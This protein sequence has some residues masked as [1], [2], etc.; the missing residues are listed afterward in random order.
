MQVSPLMAHTA[1]ASFSNFIAASYTQVYTGNYSTVVGD[2]TLNFGTGG[3]SAS[4]FTWD[5]TSN[6]VIQF[7]FD[8]SATS[9]D[10]AEDQ[11]EA[12]VSA[13]G[14]GNFATCL[15]NYSSG[16][17]A[18]CSL[19]ASN[20]TSVRV[21]ARFSVAQAGNPVATTAVS[22]LSQYLGP[23]ADVYFYDNSG[24]T[25]ARIQN[26]TSFDYGCT[27]ISIDRT[28]S[29]SSQF[30]NNN[31]SNYLSSKSFR[32]I[33]TNNTTSG[34]Y[35]I[36]LYYTQAEINGWQTATGQSIASARVVKVSNGNYI[37]DV[38]P[39]T[40]HLADVSTVAA[41]NG[42]F[43]TD[44]IISGDFSSTGFSGFG[45][46]LPGSATTLPVRWL[47]FEGAK[48][49]ETALLT[50]KTADEYNNDHFEIET[51]KNGADFYRIGIVKGNNNSSTEQ[52]YQFTDSF[53]ATG[54]NHYRLVQ[55]DIDGRKSY[56]KTISLS[57]DQLVNMVQLYPNPG[58]ENLFINFTQPLNTAVLQILSLDGKLIKQMQRGYMYRNELLHIGDLPGG[59]YL[60]KINTGTN[61]YK[62][63][64]V[65][66]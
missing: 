64:F 49:K 12:T 15:S 40:P 44:Y 14:A 60:L 50:W 5:G 7:C 6:I 59:T 33:P 10:P 42:A 51:S 22:S 37:P 36:Y 18:G 20:I 17:T 27:Q 34:H 26:L 54:I 28:G 47:S 2:N 30:W 31:T 16:A 35:V 11:M 8:N 23:N 19:G 48:D 38:T 57:F 46:G 58:K 63:K 56:S 55:V 9:A 61:T 53:P 1:T 62:V 65:K 4:T 25:M 66:Q 45:V 39:S 29:T 13:F 21:T 3:G 52:Y 43:G 41:S 24:R 32:V